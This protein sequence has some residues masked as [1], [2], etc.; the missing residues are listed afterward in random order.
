MI[1]YSCQLSVSGQQYK[2]DILLCFHG[3]S[4]YSKA[5]QCYVLRTFLFISPLYLVVP[6][7]V[8]QLWLSINVYA[9]QP[10]R[11]SC[12]CKV[13]YLTKLEAHVT[14]S[15][16]LMDVITFVRNCRPSLRWHCGN[17][18]TLSYAKLDE[19]ICFTSQCQSPK[20]QQSRLDQNWFKCHNI[21]WEYVYSTDVAVLRAGLFTRST[22]MAIPIIIIPFHS[23]LLTYY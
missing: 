2:G 7:I 5:Q 6:V 9:L 21:R 17:V 3:N 11:Y 8:L 18:L 1:L 12:T 22:K 15:C 16:R 23:C 13:C 4:G 19:T 10:N 14:T 20:F